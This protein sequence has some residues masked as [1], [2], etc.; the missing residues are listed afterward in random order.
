MKH[1]E[2][3]NKIRVYCR[4]GKDGLELVYED[5]GVGVPEAKKEKIFEK[6][7]GKGT[8]LGLHMIKIMCKVYGWTIRETGKQGKGAQ[9]TMTIPKKSFKLP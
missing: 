8:G 7:Y 2:K 1:G 9:F 5:D 4:E 3:V 6:G